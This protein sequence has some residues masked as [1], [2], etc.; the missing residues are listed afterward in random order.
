MPRGV[1]YAVH[2][3]ETIDYKLNN[4]SEPCPVYLLDRFHC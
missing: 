1:R 4:T 3:P 2:M